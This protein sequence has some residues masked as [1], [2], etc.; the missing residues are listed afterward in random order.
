[1]AKKRFTALSQMS[2]K[3]KFMNVLKIFGFSFAGVMAM[4]AGVVLYVWISG[5]FKPKYVPLETWGWTTAISADGTFEEKSEFVID[6]NKKISVDENGNQLKTENGNLIWKQE[7]D[8]DGNPV[9][10]F[11]MLG[12]NVDCTELD[13]VL[14]IDESSNA[15]SP[16]LQLVEDDNTK[17]IDK[18]ENDAD[19]L[20]LNYTVKIGQPIK[21]KPLTKKVLL[22]GEEVEVNVGG[23]VKLIATQGLKTTSCWVFVDTPVEQIDISTKQ[24][25]DFDEEKQYYN[26]YPNSK[27]DIQSV[28][29]PESS[30]VLPSTNVP[31]KKT[32]KIDEV[33]YVLGQTNFKKSKPI[34][35]ETS[36][37]EIASIDK[38][39]VVT[40]YSDKEGE[41]F[42]I[43]AYT[44]AKYND[45]DNE[46]TLDDYSQYQDPVIPYKQA[47]GKI[48]VVSSEIKFKINEITVQELTTGSKDITIPDYPVFEEGRIVFS[49]TEQNVRKNNYYVDIV[50]SN[51][52][53][54]DYKN[55]LLGKVKL[56]VGY[57]TNDAQGFGQ[58]LIIGNNQI[59]INNKIIADASQFITVEKDATLNR[60]YNY[61]VEQYSQ[62]KFYFI[63]VYEQPESEDV[64]YDYVPFTISKTNLNSIA[65]SE[66]VVVLNYNSDDDL[67]EFDLNDITVELNP[68]NSTY[69]RVL[70]F[71]P[72]T[73]VIK[74]DDTS[75]KVLINEKDCYPISISEQEAFN[76]SIVRPLKTGRANIYAVVLR[77]TEKFDGTNFGDYIITNGYAE[78]EGSSDAI[79]VTVE[80]KVVFTGI[81]YIA[82]ESDKV[83][84]YNPSLDIDDEDYAFALNS[85]IFAEIYKGGHIAVEITYNGDIDS[86]ENNRLTINH[87]TGS[88]I[89]AQVVNQNNTV[90]G[91]FTF[92][93]IANSEGYAKF[94]VLHDRESIYVVAI[95]ILSTELVGMNLTT[96]E[97]ELQAELTVEFQGSTEHD[98]LIMATDYSWQNL[99]LN[100]N[101][102][103]PE[104]D[105][106]DF[107]LNVYQIPE[108]FD[109][110]ILEQ[111]K[112]KNYNEEIEGLDESINTIAKFIRTLN[113]SE[114]IVKVFDENGEGDAS[115][116]ISGNEFVYKFVGL[117]KVLIVAESTILDICSNPIVVEFSCPTIV[118]ENNDLAEQQV[119]SYGNAISLQ[120]FEME[121]QSVTLLGNNMEVFVAT[122]DAGNYNINSLIN[123]KLQNQ[124][125]SGATIDSN[126][127]SFS[128]VNKE[129]SETVLATTDFGY[130]GAYK[131]YRLLPDY[132]II[133][134][135]G[136]AKFYAPSNLNLFASSSE[137]L[138]Y[139][140]AVNKEYKD[141]RTNGY[142]LE[143]GNKLYLPTYYEDYDIIRPEE[144]DDAN[145]KYLSDIFPVDFLN[146]FLY[147]DF[148]DEYY[149]IFACLTIANTSDDYQTNF[150]STID[151]EYFAEERDIVINLYIMPNTVQYQK[152]ISARVTPAIE[153]N[154]EYNNGNIQVENYKEQ[155]FIDLN[156]KLVFNKKIDGYDV[157]IK[158]ID[159]AVNAQTSDDIYFYYVD[160]NTKKVEYYVDITDNAELLTQNEYDALDDKTNYKTYFILTSDI[161]E[162]IEGKEYYTFDEIL[163]R[164]VLVEM[165]DE[166]NLNS[167]FEKVYSSQEYYTQQI[168]YE[169]IENPSS[170]YINKYY[171]LVQVNYTTE[172][173]T[174]FDFV[175][176]ADEKISSQKE[177]YILDN[178]N[179]ALVENP[180]ES[181]IQ[182]YYEKV[183]ETKY[184]D[185][186]LT[187]DKVV[188]ITKTY[189]YKKIYSILQENKEISQ[190]FKRAELILE[191]NDEFVKTIDTNVVQEKEY[192]QLENDDYVL[193][194]NPIDAEIENYFEKYSKYAI[195]YDSSLEILNSPINL[196]IKINIEIVKDGVS[197]SKTISFYYNIMFE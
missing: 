21:L 33:N 129:I 1:M 191:N 197:V 96:D 119:L 194:E 66:N 177:Y 42:T 32:L 9:Y 94:E 150:D 102:E 100:L 133:N 106:K 54:I 58:Q 111:F 165:P 156:Q 20:Y 74:C 57:E 192:Y 7:V 148:V 18:D 190:I 144:D 59:S 118:I 172:I 62:N 158:D 113:I 4:L 142:V 170:N 39:G 178:G 93:I 182:N 110:N 126:I 180:Q 3:E 78:I 82:E 50:L 31:S 174:Y 81:D 146:S 138:P 114:N 17:I 173:A 153:A 183:V 120:G 5:G 70:F 43:Y 163:N 157:E 55:T 76:Y 136:S 13:A 109:L 49:N 14:K 151:I 2:R 38:N 80:N 145:N 176:T 75:I 155:E 15:E 89:N 53:D 97:D 37:S 103:S 34:Y 84:N 186:A 121:G 104:A 60:T 10:E 195:G 67:E 134:N 22:N 125:V 91:K 107:Y 117:G 179:Y 41:E 141:P 139:L 19:K 124:N 25:F 68:T 168:S 98:N 12:A 36:N 164:F 86:L 69:S 135:I 29:T 122:T 45:I 189:Y 16:I 115:I 48:R 193:V 87:F 128:D 112:G 130:Q 95:K 181:E 166:N 63:F 56:Y 175:K 8:E 149:H 108:N 40:I 99:Y 77:T 161:G 105:E 147:P 83:A 46:P 47:M 123:F 184:Y 152:N 51:E 30:I 26:V 116:W 143:K 23:W 167:Y 132:N 6:G 85:N 88:N 65:T 28:L 35:F 187:A 92:D 188:N 64:F 44:I 185:F 71:T 73:D 90:A 79:N 131:N 171:E 196:R 52:I 169:I 72:N 162:P 27:I 101:F 159:F 127:L 140:I 137:N 160:D 154:F 24:N 11:V 61:K